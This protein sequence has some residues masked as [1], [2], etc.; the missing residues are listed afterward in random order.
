MA[1][2]KSD[3][4]D[5]IKEHIKA[6]ELFENHQTVQALTQLYLQKGER[7]LRIAYANLGMG[8][9]ES[10]LM[11]ASFFVWSIVI[12]YYSMFHSARA[13]LAKIKVQFSNRKVHEALINAMY[14]YYVYPGVLDK[15]LFYMLESA[16]EM[17]D[18]SLELMEKLEDARDKRGNLNY[19]VAKSVS[20]R[21]AAELLR[22]ATEFNEAM[23][24]L[25]V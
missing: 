16:K 15:K 10:N 13:A 3:V 20:E 14:H 2:N 23:K 5:A 19:Q 18:K 8:K 4:A 11:Q 21:E 24:K 17:R 1:R 12:G 25:V 6:K 22:N 9:K 7:D